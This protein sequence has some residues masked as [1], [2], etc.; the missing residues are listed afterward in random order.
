MVADE[1]MCRAAWDTAADLELSEGCHV[2]FEMR[3]TSQRGVWHFHAVAY[4]VR[5]R[6]VGR[7]LGSIAGT[8]PNGVAGTLSA[9]V[10]G[11][12]NSLSQMV[13]NLRASEY[14]EG[15]G[16]GLPRSTR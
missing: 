8:Y 12:M 15:L 14:Q 5:E 11:K 4:S 13:S 7:R 6:E 10:F 2:T 3:T 1:E 9:F 16:H